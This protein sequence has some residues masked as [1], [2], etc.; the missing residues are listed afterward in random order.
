MLTLLIVD[1]EKLVREGIKHI[2]DWEKLGFSICGEAADGEEAFEKIELYK[3]DLV[4]L[5]IRM[6]GMLGTEIIERARKSGYDGEI[7]IL[8][9]YSEFSYAQKA[10]QNGVSN[11]ITKP[12]DD[13]RL[14]NCIISLKK[15]IEGKNER[16]VSHEQYLKKVKKMVLYDL[17]Q[18]EKESHVLNY[19]ELGLQATVFQVIMYENYTPYTKVNDFSEILMISNQNNQSLEQLVVQQKDVILLKGEYALGCFDR[20]AKRYEKGYQR[21]SLMDSLF[22]TCGMPVNCIEDIHNSFRQ[23]LCLLKRRFFCDLGQHIL[24]WNDI[25]EDTAPVV[26]DKDDAKEWSLLIVDYIQSLNML[27][28]EEGLGRLKEELCKKN[29][30]VL[31]VKHYLIDIFLQVKQSVIHFCEGQKDFSIPIGNNVSIINY[32][33]NSFYLYEIMDFFKKEL[34]A[35]IN[36]ISINSADGVFTNIINYID[37]N[38]ANPLKLEKIAELYGYNSSYLGKLFAK[39][40]NCGFTSY[41]EKVRIEHAKELLVSTDMK[42]YEIASKVGYKYIDI[43]NRKFKNNVGVSPV[44]YRRN[45]VGK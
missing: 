28:L 33:E 14:E 43:F 13:K 23:S 35:V 40:M 32:I 29:Y 25:P 16:K 4:L 37:Y 8:S 22:I 26:L 24:T 39:K 34:S 45:R 9:G 27:K 7:V 31:G 5:D 15:K 36:S 44:V 17:L 2:L 10:L 6:P 1:D 41:L 3:P 12:I 42:V 21:G 30:E 38:Y 11:Y 19:G 20:W 18:G